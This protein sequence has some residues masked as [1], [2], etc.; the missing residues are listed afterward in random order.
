VV[1]A[2]ADNVGANRHV[3]QGSREGKRMRSVIDAMKDGVVPPDAVEQVE[4]K[5]IVAKYPVLAS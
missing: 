1:S 2:S 5:T 4:T 3:E